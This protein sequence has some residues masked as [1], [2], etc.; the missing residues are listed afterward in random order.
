MIDWLVVLG[1]LG[2]TANDIYSAV[3][4]FSLKGRYFIFIL[5]VNL[6]LN[7]VKLKTHCIVIL[8]RTMQY[9]VI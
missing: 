7:T 5:H 9:L 8:A 3:L 1:V 4:P 6:K 2:R